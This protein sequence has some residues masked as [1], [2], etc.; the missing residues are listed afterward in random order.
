MGVHAIFER[1]PRARGAAAIA[2]A[3]HALAVRRFGHHDGVGDFLSIET[4][5]AESRLELRFEELGENYDRILKGLGTLGARTERLL[6]SGTRLETLSLNL[7]GLLSQI[8]DIDITKVILDMNR[9]EQT[10]QLTQAT[11]SRLIQNSLLNF[12]R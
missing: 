12:L 11:G 6:S 1:G 8:E 7:D 10:L 9:S 5:L 2:V 4:Q 3:D